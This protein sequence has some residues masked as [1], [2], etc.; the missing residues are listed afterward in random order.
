MPR[1]TS[2]SK[3]AFGKLQVPFSKGSSLP[4]RAIGSLSSRA[5]VLM[6]NAF[7]DVKAVVIDMRICR[8]V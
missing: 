3:R 2:S 4:S 5:Q 8:C 1:V 7:V 6:G